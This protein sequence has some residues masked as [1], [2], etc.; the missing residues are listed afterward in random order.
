RQLLTESVLIALIG[1]AAGI[2]VAFVGVR[3]LLA[4]APAGRIPRID[5]VHL[6]GWVLLFTLAVAVI[7]GILFGVVPAQSGARR[8]PQEA[9]AQG[10]RLVGGSHHGLRSVFVTAEI[11]LALMLLSGAGLM[12]KSFF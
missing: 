12:I 4:L 6:N 7:T 9:L 5:E 11:T 8:E 2:L 10:T 3:A 1:A